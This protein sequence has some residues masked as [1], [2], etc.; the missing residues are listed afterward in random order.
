M[1]QISTCEYRAD[2]PMALDLH[3]FKWLDET[4]IGEVNSTGGTSL[5]GEYEAGADCHPLIHYTN[6]GPYFKGF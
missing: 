5:V 6:G 1:F 4:E 2:A 3:Q